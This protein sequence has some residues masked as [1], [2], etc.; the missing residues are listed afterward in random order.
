MKKGKSI[1]A[2][3]PVRNPIIVGYPRIDVVPKPQVLIAKAKYK[4]VSA[5]TM[6]HDQT[7]IFVT[8]LIFLMPNVTGQGT[9]HLVAGTLDPIVGLIFVSVSSTINIQFRGWRSRRK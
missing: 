2:D 6:V 7:A 9:R 3:M 4:S 1:N 8:L 5:H